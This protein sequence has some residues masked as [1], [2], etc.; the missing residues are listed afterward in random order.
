MLILLLRSVYCLM[1]QDCSSIVGLDLY[2]VTMV[3]I[4]VIFAACPLL[5]QWGTMQ[6]G[7]QIQ[8]LRPQTVDVD[9]FDIAFLKIK[10]EILFGV[11]S[12]HLFVPSRPRHYTCSALL[13]TT[14]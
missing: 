8:A 4:E 6:R 2:A 1:Y 7:Y 9:D 14:G 12:Q 10:A 11:E 5:V 13:H 3:E